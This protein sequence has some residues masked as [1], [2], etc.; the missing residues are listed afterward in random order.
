MGTSKKDWLLRIFDAMGSDPASGSYIHPPETL[1][2]VW[3]FM[4][5]IG[6]WFISRSN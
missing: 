3:L 6:E 1:D 5:S 2:D 4:N